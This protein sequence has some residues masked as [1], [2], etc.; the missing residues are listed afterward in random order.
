MGSCIWASSQVRTAGAYQE[1]LAPAGRGLWVSNTVFSTKATKAETGEAEGVGPGLCSQMFCRNV[2]REE[3]GSLMPLRASSKPACDHSTV[4]PFPSQGGGGKKPNKISRG[5]SE[6][7][8]LGG[9]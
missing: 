8:Y 3:I 9:K 4:E 1:R 6:E 2:R 7:H 5:T